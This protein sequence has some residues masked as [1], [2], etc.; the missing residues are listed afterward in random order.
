MCS[1]R[2]SVS[3]FSS[4]DRTSASTLAASATMR[5]SGTPGEYLSGEAFGHEAEPVE[6]V[7]VLRQIGHLDHRTFDSRLKCR[8]ISAFLVCDALEIGEVS[9]Q[10]SQSGR[11]LA[12]AY[13]VVDVCAPSRRV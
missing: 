3:S 11:C 7:D 8:Q 4:A 5:M 9:A 1:S 6:V 13:G 10:A 12:R 2:I